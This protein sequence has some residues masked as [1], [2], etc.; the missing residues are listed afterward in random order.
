METNPV[1]ETIFVK[2]QKDL[3]WSIIRP[4]FILDTRQEYLILGLRVTPCY[5]ILDT[6]HKEA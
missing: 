2:I 4:I 1:S 5:V 3:R 6:K